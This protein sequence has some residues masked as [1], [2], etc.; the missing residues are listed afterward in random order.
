MLSYDGMLALLKGYNNALN[1]GKQKLTSEDLLQGLRQISGTNGFQGVS[2]YIAFDGQG[3]P[4]DK[5]IVILFVNQDGFFQMKPT[6]LGHF[7][8]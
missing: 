7:L 6:S 4:A 8:Q 5:S 3:N 2:G 1:T